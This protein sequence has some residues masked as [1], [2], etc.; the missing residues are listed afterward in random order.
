[1]PV[2]GANNLVEIQHWLNY[3]YSTNVEYLD[4]EVE[5]K[6]E[7][8]H[9]VLVVGAGPVGLTIALLLQR[10]G[11]KVLVVEK[12]HQP[13]SE[14]RAIWVHPRT[15]EIWKQIG[16]TREALKEGVL[17]SAIQMH[18]QGKKQAT[19]PY[20]GATVSEFPHG[21]MLEQSRTQR[22]LLAIAERANI[23]I[24]WNCELTFTAET[25]NGQRSAL[26]QAGKPLEV[27]TKF[28]VGADGGSSTVRHL[29]GVN[30]NGG[31][32]DSAFFVADVEAVTELDHDQAH[33]NFAGKSTVAV[34]PL[35]G[36]NRFRLVGNLVDQQKE[37][38][39]AGYGRALEAD[40]IGELVKSNKLPMVISGIGWT[41]TY[42]SHYR[43]ADTF[44]SG[45]VFLAGDAGHL[46]SPAGGL[47][48]NTGVADAENLSWRLADVINGASRSSLDNYTQERRSAAKGVI[49]SSD[50]LF[51]LQ[52]DTRLPFVLMRNHR[53]PKLVRLITKFKLGQRIAFLALSGTQSRYE[54][55]NSSKRAIGRVKLGRLLPFATDQEIHKLLSKSTGLHR[56]ISIGNS[57]QAQ[58]KIASADVPFESIRLSRDDSINIVGR[59]VEDLYL[60]VRPD[61]YVAWIG[62][63]LELLKLEI[64]NYIDGRG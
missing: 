24:W 3:I 39:D 15:L 14:S 53:L 40:E 63:D 54:I 36:K 35:P 31:T 6:P 58:V 12:S 50:R 43:V 33:L 55:R 27:E 62:S 29:A 7:L 5:V 2:A 32:Y 64:A 61:S 52:A 34:L 18:V 44:R 37:S 16:M 45:N 20:D 38:R 42:R 23:P 47:G 22:L 60:W 17:V 48:M 9:D 57:A 11:I 8:E 1:M 25:A 19:L 26:I 49:Q 41:T 30:L 59:L 51:T 46:H 28:I 10:R 4:S 56:I 13:V 21:L